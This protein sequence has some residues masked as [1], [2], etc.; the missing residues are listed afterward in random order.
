M[1]GKEYTFGE[2]RLRPHQRE[3]LRDGRSVR[4]EKIPF[5]LLVL[6]VERAGDLIPRDEIAT[7]IWRGSFQDIDASLN[8]AVRKLRVALG[9]QSERPRFVRTIVGQGYRFS[10]QVEVV[11]VPDTGAGVSR[12]MG[13]PVSKTPIASSKLRHW[14]QKLAIV[15][16]GIPAAVWCVLRPRLQQ[17]IGMI[18][19]LPF[20]S[21]PEDASQKYFSQG[22]TEEI[23]TQLGRVASSEVGVIAGPSIRR[24]GGKNPNLRQVASDLGI[25]YVVTGSIQRE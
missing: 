19:V 25:G 5:D 3:L 10:M 2:F 12:G 4:L 21:F 16:V 24:Y 1:A 15:L 8:T 18:A 13:D 9:D 7:R 20:E 11:E 17:D 6:L 22:M 14:Q 23:I